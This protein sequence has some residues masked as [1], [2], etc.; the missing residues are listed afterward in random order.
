MATITPARSRTQRFFIWAGA[1]IAFALLVLGIAVGI[2]ES[3]LPD[4]DQLKKRGDLGQMIRMRA[5]DGSVLISLGPTFGRWLTYD[6]I[7]PTMR[8]A[9][10]AVEDKRFRSH[11]GVDPIGIARSFEVRVTSGKWKQGG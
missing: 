2:A 1:I 3:Q 9:M 7:P 6:E 4:Y 10:I 5:A 8:A 11:P